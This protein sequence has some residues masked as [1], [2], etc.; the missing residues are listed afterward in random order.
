MQDT[1]PVCFTQAF[2][3]SQVLRSVPT[4]S[5][6]AAGTH[7][8]Y[9][10]LREGE[11]NL[12]HCSCQKPLLLYVMKALERQNIAKTTLLKLVTPE[13]PPSCFWMA[14]L[15]EA[16]SKSKSRGREGSTFSAAWQA[17]AVFG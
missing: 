9:R 4:F 8:A 1:E 13:T 16:R 2:P 12:L 5:H 3:A 10:M 11:S 17:K 7:T 15:K 14:G 6:V